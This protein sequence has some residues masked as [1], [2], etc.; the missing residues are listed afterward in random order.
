[1]AFENVNA[2]SLKN[3]LIQCKNSLNYSITSS[4]IND[5]ANP[6]VWQCDAQKNLK[7]A[8]TNL[9]DKRYK[10]LE[11][12]IE[13]Y[14]NVASYIEEYKDLEY[15][16]ERLEIN[17]GNLRKNL[18]YWGKRKDRWG[19]PLKDKDGNYKYGYLLN[20]NVQNQMN[21]ITRQI[22]ENEN[23]MKNLKNK[24]SNSV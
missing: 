18:Y 7:V 5:I 22:E 17:Y 12:K 1:M 10:E 3:A 21:S 9:K 2:S 23:E 13:K 11:D 20:Y 19:N 6:S 15:E 14:L 16:N 24:V 8:L 4:L